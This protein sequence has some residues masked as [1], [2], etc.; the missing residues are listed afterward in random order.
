MCDFITIK[1][2]P[3]NIEKLKEALLKSGENRMD[4]IWSSELDYKLLAVSPSDCWIS[5]KDALPADQQDVIVSCDGVSYK[6]TFLTTEWPL[7]VF[8]IYRD[9]S[10]EP[11]SLKS[12]RVSHWMEWPRPLVAEKD[13]VHDSL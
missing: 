7:P 6:A 12:G 10:G 1:H 8:Y 11:V 3:E 5:I 13:K 9:D 2:N 4:L